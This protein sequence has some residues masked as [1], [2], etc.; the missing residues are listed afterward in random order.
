VA[1]LTQE[2]KEFI[3]QRY[4]MYDRPK[5]I[6]V[7]FKDKY[8]IEI[9]RQQIDTYNPRGVKAANGN[10]AKSLMAAF[11][12]QRAAFVG[13]IDNIPIAQRS[14]RLTKLQSMFEAAFDKGNLSMAASLLA[15]AKEEVEEKFAGKIEVTHKG[16]VAVT[17]ELTPEDKRN[18]IVDRIAAVMAEAKRDAPREPTTH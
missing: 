11:E 6:G 5:E 17:D 12:A 7:A 18:A 15:Q 4:A 2:Q 10:I 14:Y 9:S 8:G 13:T 16:K 1:K 3:V